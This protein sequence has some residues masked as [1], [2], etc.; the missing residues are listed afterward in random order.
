MLGF[1]K[2]CFSAKST[3]PVRDSLIILD[4]LVN[5]YKISNNPLSIKYAT[6]FL[7]IARQLN[8]SEKIV[9]AYLLLGIAYFQNQ[10]DSSFYYYSEAAKI[11]EETN[12]EK[13]KIIILYNLAAHH[14]LSYDYKNAVTLLDSSIRLAQLTNDFQGISN[15]NNMLG[16]I[17]FNIHDFE[18]AET[19]FSS[20]LKVAKEHGLF[21]QV[22]VAM[23]N[24]ARLEFEP[25]TIKSISMQLEALTYLRKV[26]G[27]EEEMANILI[28]IGN[29]Y[30][31][32]DSA[33]R[34][35]RA[36]LSIAEN[37]QLPVR[38]IGAYNNMAYSYLEKGNLSEAESCVRDHAI[39]IAEKYELSDWLSSL[40]DTFSDVCEAQGDL[41][42]A[43]VMQKKALRERKIDYKKK[44]AEQVQLLAAV[45][46]LKN[47]E[48]TIQNEEKKL[49][50]Q[51]NQLQKTE[52]WL[53][54]RIQ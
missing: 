26:R 29:R 7:V 41:K 25:D 43:L 49:L 3:Y 10:K 27:T 6:Q 8:S 24:L 4:S 52:L 42:K 44:A 1:S 47:K 16:L 11:A 15:G 53:A 13:Q 23:G 14:N 2:N 54:A 18:S 39:P 46:D 38:T 21:E 32:P 45:L 36:A 5:H 37:A 30:L 34:Y 22:G 51:R 40:Y 31:N 9:D 48:L 20:A 35:Y 28:N 19:H 33:L 50:I 12:L 17:K